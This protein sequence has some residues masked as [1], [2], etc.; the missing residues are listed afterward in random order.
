MIRRP[1]RSTR[2]DTLFPYTTLFRSSN[3][4]P[5]GRKGSQPN[6][7]QVESNQSRAAIDA[8]PPGSTS[9][10]S[11]SDCLLLNMMVTALR[12]KAPVRVWCKTNFYHDGAGSDKKA[13]LCASD[14]SS[15]AKQGKQRRP[16]IA[17]R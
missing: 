2:T 12:I 15:M 9:V 10:L 5:L 3:T 6:R 7:V 8:C 11:S 4:L 1:P 13:A 17:G 14:N 16:K